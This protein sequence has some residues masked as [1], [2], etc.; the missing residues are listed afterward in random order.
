[1]I[2]V[3]LYIPEV[4]QELDFRVDENE[5][6]ARIKE[7][8]GRILKR[9]YG[10]SQSAASLGYYGLFSADQQRE[11]EDENTLNKYGI[12]DGARLIFV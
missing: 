11:M 1:M 3:Q 4:G 6:I 10:D 8:I 5:K 12:R 7:D 9:K 2:M